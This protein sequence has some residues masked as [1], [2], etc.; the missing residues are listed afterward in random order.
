[1]DI[2]TV[3]YLNDERQGLE[4]VKKEWGKEL[5]ICRAPHACKIMTIKPGY[6]VSLHWHKDK[7]ETF[8]LVSGALAVEICLADGTKKGIVL[9][10]PLSSITLPAMTPHTF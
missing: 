5:I 8:V 10:D 9:R 2:S 6:Q 3:H 4:V 7:S 1:M